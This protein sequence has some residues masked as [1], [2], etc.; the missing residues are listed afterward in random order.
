MKNQITKA[1]LFSFLILIVICLGLLIPLIVS[2]DFVIP[3]DN[4]FFPFDFINL[5]FLGIPS[6]LVL[7]ALAYTLVNSRRNEIEYEDDFENFKKI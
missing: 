7:F 5:L 4:N 2:N 6:F 1:N 3:K